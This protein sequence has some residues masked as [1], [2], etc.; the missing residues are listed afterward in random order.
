L[1][2]K[3]RFGQSIHGLIVGDDLLKVFK[4]ERGFTRENAE[5]KMVATIGRRVDGCW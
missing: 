1:V 5:E 2:I 4:K 3:R